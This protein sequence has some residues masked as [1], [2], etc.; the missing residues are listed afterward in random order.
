[1]KPPGFF[2][3][4]R[5]GLDFAT[6]YVK[7]IQMEFEHDRF[8]QKAS[9]KKQEPVKIVDSSDNEYWNYCD[10]CGTRLES[11]R[12]RYVCPNCGFFHSCSEP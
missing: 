1:M 4:A 5:A 8:S 12:C 3:Y 10:N 7:I 6:A 2:L 9:E 11:F